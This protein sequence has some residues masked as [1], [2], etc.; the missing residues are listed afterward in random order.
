MQSFAAQA[1]QSPLPR[2]NQI[3][4]TLR[5]T[6]EHGAAAPTFG[7]LG[8]IAT[9]CEDLDALIT[10]HV[11]TLL[12]ALLIDDDAPYSEIHPL[13]VAI[14]C[15]VVT[16][17]RAFDAQTRSTIMAAAL[18][19]NLGMFAL[20]EEVANKRALSPAQRAVVDEHP[21]R[22]ASLLAEAGVTDPLWLDIVRHHHEKVDGSGYPLGLRGAAISRPTRLI[23]LADIYAAMVLPR[24]YR[25]GV[26]AQN[27][28]RELFLLR[29]THIDAELAADFIHLLGVYPPGI[30]V[31]MKSGELGVVIR[32]GEAKRRG[33]VIGCFRS[34]HGGAYTKPLSR[35]T[36][37]GAIEI[38]EVLPRQ[39]LP[40]SVP[41]LYGMQ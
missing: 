20:H 16:R 40:C 23:A 37:P 7:L 41:A 29:G 15:E 24:Q 11:D 8:A 2:L 6:L 1:D 25:D 22:G 18:T 12:C 21:L 35:D 14:T 19:C 27:A 13:M 30:F 10:E 33:P 32:R 36:S 5:I 9:L 17:N 34:A 4:H 3:R 28:L 38:D 26:H 39:F 31:R